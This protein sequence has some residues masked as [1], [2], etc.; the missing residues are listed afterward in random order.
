M[1]S[2]DEI[3]RLL[4]S[5]EGITRKFVLP[6][7]ISKLRLSSYQGDQPHSLGED[8]AAIRTNSDE[9][10]LLTTD[11]IIEELC[12][13]HPKAAGFNV[14]L[15]SVMDIYAAGGVPTSFAVALS[16]SDEAVGEELLDGLIEGSN[17]F[18]VPIVRGHTNPW[19]NSTYVVGSAT[20]TVKKDDMLTAGGAVTGDRLVLIFDRVGHRGSSYKLGWDSVT[21]R[22]EDD[23][24]SRLSI[25]EILAC[26]HLLNAAK[27]VSVAG[28]IGTA[29][30]LVEYSGKGGVVDLDAVRE[31]CPSEISLE[32]WLR[33]F[34]SLGFLLA[35]PEDS[36][37]EVSQLVSDYQ[38]KM[39]VIGTIDEA[40]SLR[41]RMGRE[42]RVMFD[43]SRGPVLT[44]RS[45]NEF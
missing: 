17:K 31:S 22:S 36:L 33:M 37:G 45:K 34:I 19:A 2:L 26:R 41:L 7:I 11:A 43:F 10:I 23:V 6:Q 15:A 24:V 16:Y 14:V 5:Y 4:H 18:R 44:P 9:V 21:D 38:M 13:N 25:M 3:V 20:G 29:G 32:D 35:V 28:M 42:E 1:S 39:C 12:L 30:M 8:S 40:P 27:D